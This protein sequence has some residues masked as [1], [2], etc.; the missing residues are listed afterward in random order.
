MELQ[1]CRMSASSGET[2][3]RGGLLALGRTLLCLCHRGGGSSSPRFNCC[4]NWLHS[5]QHGQRAGRELEEIS[6]CHAE[7][8]RR[9]GGGDWAEIEGQSPPSEGHPGAPGGHFPAVS[10]PLNPAGSAGS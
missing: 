7:A 10:C 2:E 5:F 6:H 3:A 9:G 1:C 8:L 4:D